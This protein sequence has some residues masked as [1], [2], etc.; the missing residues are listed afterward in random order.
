ML[1]K[2]VR[3]G[4]VSRMHDLGGWMHTLELDHC[5]PFEALAELFDA[6]NSVCAS[7]QARVEAT[8][9]ICS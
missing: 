7:T 5:A 4:K 3:A 1:S 9:R 6:R 8:E 2:L